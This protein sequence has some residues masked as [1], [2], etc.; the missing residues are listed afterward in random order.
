ILREYD[1]EVIQS[2]TLSL[3]SQLVNPITD[4][5]DTQ[6]ALLESLDTNLNINYQTKISDTNKIPYSLVSGTP[7][8][9]V[10]LN[11]STDL[12]NINANIAT[13]VN[14]SVYDTDKTSL[15]NRFVPIETKLSGY[16]NLVTSK[17]FT[18]NVGAGNQ[19]NSIIVNAPSTA[20]A[21]NGILLMNNAASSTQ[22]GL[23]HAGSTGTQNLSNGSIGFYN[24]TL[25]SHILQLRPDG[26][27]SVTTV[28][29]ATST[30]TGAM[31][32]HGGLGVAKKV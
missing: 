16:D 5:I 20:T 9:S 15:N 21:G 1:S 31:R 25:A 27:V 2:N 4:L 13:K 18:L 7:D 32:I 8:L 19:P 29:D 3:V 6:Q 14:Q 24:F 10:Y 11:R 28:T 23:Y 22:W 26:Q 17:Q 30:T 12:S